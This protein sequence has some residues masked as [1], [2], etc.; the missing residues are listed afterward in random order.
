MAFYLLDKRNIDC[1]ERRPVVEWGKKEDIIFQ[2]LD[3]CYEE[4]AID[5][6]IVRESFIGL[7][8]CNIIF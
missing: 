1:N 6:I 2:D 7:F 3:E 5:F 4:R 8:I